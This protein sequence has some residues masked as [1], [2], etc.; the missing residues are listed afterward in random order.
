MHCSAS[1]SRLFFALVFLLLL[2]LPC[3]ALADTSQVPKGG[4][5]FI[6]EEGLNLTAAGVAG[7]TRIFWW[8]PGERISESA[9]AGDVVISDPGYFD[10]SSALFGGMTG[11]W[12]LPDNNILFYVQEPQITIR[13][14][15][16]DADY[17]A[18]GGWV[19]QGDM[20]GFRVDTNMFVMRERPGVEGVPVTINF[21]TAQNVRFIQLVGPSGETTWLKNI[22]VASSPYSTG[23]IWDT[24]NSL[25]PVGTYTVFAETDPLDSVKVTVRIGD[26]NPTIELVTGETAAVPA[27]A[28]TTGTMTV[29]LENVTPQVTVPP[30]TALTTP[31][32]GSAPGPVDNM[33]ESVMPTTPATPQ[34]T[35]GPV[36]GITT[37]PA[38]NTTERAIPTTQGTSP[39]TSAPARKATPIDSQPPLSAETPG[40]GAIATFAACVAIVVVL[41]RRRH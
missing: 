32:Y 4:T 12:Y 16:T 41:A 7:G 15:D 11:P 36:S 31:A 5:V 29:P 6:G 39:P 19:P 25:Y 2:H 26:A 20:V 1:N 40:F 28:S 14:F 17:D 8:P 22:P 9:P 37:G 3:L 18:T 34:Q 13:I 23:P 35:S 38:G 24:G 27:T 33:T 21:K 30:T 10:I